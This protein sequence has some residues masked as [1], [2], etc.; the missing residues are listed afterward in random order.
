MI[1]KEEVWDFLNELWEEPTT[2]DAIATHLCYW[3]TSSYAFY[4]FVLLVQ[5]LT[6]ERDI[7]SELATNQMSI[8]IQWSNFFL[9][10]FT[11]LI[12][13]EISS[14]IAKAYWDYRRDNL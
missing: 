14:Y 2:L 10:I 1:T 5:T 4:F 11:I 7:V 9:N 3:V 8:L 6:Y 12:I 13:F